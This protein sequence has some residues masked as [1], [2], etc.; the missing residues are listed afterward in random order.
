LSWGTV[1]TLLRTTTT[2][3]TFSLRLEL[4]GTEHHV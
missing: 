3:T 2:T 1:S 4:E